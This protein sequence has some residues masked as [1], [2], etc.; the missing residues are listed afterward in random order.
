MDCEICFESFNRSEK[1]PKVLKNCGHTFCE[2][3]VGQMIKDSYLCCPHC[4]V[5]SNLL[6]EDYPINNYAL[7]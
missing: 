3:C 1:L 2:S 4:R 5:E 6:K 7:L